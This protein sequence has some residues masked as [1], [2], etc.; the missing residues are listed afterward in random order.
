MK[1]AAL[2]ILE[3]L[4]LNAQKFTG[5]R[6]PDHAPVLV[7]FLG[8]VGTVPGSLCVKFEVCIFSH[9]GTISQKILP[10]SHD[11][12]QA[13]ILK[14]FSGSSRARCSVMTPPA[15]LKRRSEGTLEAAGLFAR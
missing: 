15:V 14:L 12:E 10:G 7:I 6:D 2:T 4:A 8:H 3:L 11:P 9:F 13:P 1:S 5:S